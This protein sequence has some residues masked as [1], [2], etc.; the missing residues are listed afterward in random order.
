MHILHPDENLHPLASLSYANKLCSYL[1]R[2]DLKFNIGYSVLW[3]NSLCLNVL[4]DSNPL[5]S[6]F[7]FRGYFHDGVCG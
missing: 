1:P 7:M 6:R 2:F 5:L 3:R 4:S